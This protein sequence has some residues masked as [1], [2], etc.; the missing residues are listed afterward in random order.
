LLKQQRHVDVIVPLKTTMLSYK[1]AVQLAVL[2]DAWHSH[3]SRAH[4][5]IAFVQSVAHMWEECHVP[6]NA[7]VIRYWN[8]K[9]DILDYIVLVT[10]DQQLTGPW[11]VRHY[12]ERPEI[13][14]D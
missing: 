4:Q 7:C 11:I 3:P 10:T 9:K 14:Q 13:E 1:E 5:H 2:Q 8:R 6:L 12:E